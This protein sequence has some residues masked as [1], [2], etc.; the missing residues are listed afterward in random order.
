SIAKTQLFSICAAVAVAHELDLTEPLIQKGIKA[1]R[2]ANGRMRVL[3]GI[4]SSVII[5]DT[6]N[7]SPDAVKTA[8]DTL[9]ENK[10]PQ[11]IAVLGNMNELGRFS[12]DAHSKVGE[13]CDPKQLDMV[14]T[15]GPDANR[16]LAAAA[17]KQG[18][19]VETFDNPYAAA[20]FLKEAIR[21]QALILAKGSQNGVFAE[22]TVKQ[23]LA[24][25]R[26]VSKLVRQEPHWLKIKAKQFKT[27]R[28]V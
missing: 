9:Y 20:D 13:Y 3:E 11:K 4:N 25:S 10:A 28:G 27:V 21:P 1:I 14:L 22:E 24:D 23:I 7:A 17:K 2:P 18:C 6:Y 12:P 26:D 15:I 19:E 8:L 5:D 16:Y